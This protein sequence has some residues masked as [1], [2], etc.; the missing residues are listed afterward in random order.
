MDEVPKSL[1]ILTA[2]LLSKKL[3]SLNV[4]DNALGEAGV[5]GLSDF[6]TNSK[7]LTELRISNC[8]LGPSG[9]SL[10]FVT[11]KNLDLSVIKIGR[12]RL[13]NVGAEAFSIYL[14]NKI[15]LASVSIKQNGIRKE[16]M[17]AFLTELV[18]HTNLKVYK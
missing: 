6:L 12:N 2:P 16:G 13:E 10:L 7:S 18:T 15:N 14:H 11:I 3:K 9:A 8:G 4:S 17:D 1:T 5:K